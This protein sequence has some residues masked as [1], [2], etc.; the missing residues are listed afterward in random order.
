MPPLFWLAH[1]HSRD[2]LAVSSL[3]SIR[4]FFILLDVRHERLFLQ[5][6]CSLFILL[7]LVSVVWHDL[8]YKAPQDE[9]CDSLQRESISTLFVSRAAWAVTLCSDRDCEIWRR[10]SVT[11]LYSERNKWFCEHDDP[12]S[13]IRVLLPHLRKEIM[14]MLMI[15]PSCLDQLT[16]LK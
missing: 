11:L 6:W 9:L 2:Q 4:S 5:S 10:S 1:S 7:F 13:L 16:D 3:S 8:P 14:I 15:L 12:F